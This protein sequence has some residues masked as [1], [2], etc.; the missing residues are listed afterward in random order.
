MDNRLSQERINK[1]REAKLTDDQIVDS[2]VRNDP[3][4]GERIYKARESGINNSTILKSIEK[5]LNNSE[6]P[7]SSN[8]PESPDSSYSFFS[9]ETDKSLTESFN[10]IGESYRKGLNQS[11][12]GL[13]AG[14]KPEI[15]TKDP[16]FWLSL[17]EQ[18]GTL[19]GDSPYIAAGATLGGVLGLEAG[20]IGAAV[21]GGFGS[22]ALP[23]FLKESIRQYHEHVDSGENLSFGEFLQRSDKVANS[24][25]KEGA[26]GVILGNINK[27]MPELLKIPGLDKLFKYTPVRK[28][29]EIGIEA[30]TL[31][32]A[33]ALSEGRLPTSRDFGNAMALVLGVKATNLPASIRNLVEYDA[34]FTESVQRIAKAEGLSH[35]Q[36]LSKLW[37]ATKNYAKQKLGRPIKGEILKEDVEILKEQAKQNESEVTFETAKGST[38]EVNENGTT[39]RTKKYRT[40]HGEFEQGLMKPSDKTWYVSEQD[41]IKLG[42]VQTSGDKK[43]LVELPDGRVGMMYT[44][45]P[46][47]GKVESRTVITPKEYPEEGLTPVEI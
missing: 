17:V 39:T 3:E 30:T 28:A 26:F 33:P 14:N 19:T 2:I 45:G 7:N 20:P 37:D 41:A 40:E 36:V 18:A 12:S 5:R 11:T 22:M 13:L 34:A 21:G 15:N 8:I 16:G 6:I 31:A 1:A 43:K 44:E 35:E 24:T 4:F 47:K 29:A 10:Q 38:Y 27:V 9:P 46:N 23:A 32:T 25:L 42:E